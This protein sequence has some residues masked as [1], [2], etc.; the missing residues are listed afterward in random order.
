MNKPEFGC[1]PI[2]T[3][4]TFSGRYM[5]I[6]DPDP[7]DVDL[8]SISHALGSICRFGGHCPQFYSVAEHSVLAFEL[9]SV[10]G[11]DDEQLKAVLLH[12]SAEAYI[13]DVVKPLKREMPIYHEIEAKMEKA[14]G[15]HFGIDFAKHHDVIKKYDNLM[16]KA[17]KNFFWPEDS[18]EW[19][20]FE[21][22]PLV[23]VHFS[24]FLPS[25]AA[26]VF[27]VYARGLLHI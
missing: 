20:G 7:A 17:E 24:C 8:E 3:I 27:D 15:A 2:P 14:I 16:L 21:S 4:R 5:N 10:D 6:I 13:S 12:D 18:V 19:Y 26:R 9:A 23:D 25:W 22:V 1:T 11:C